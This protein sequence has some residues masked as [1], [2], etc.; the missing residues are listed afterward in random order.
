MVL[1]YDLRRELG[2]GTIAPRRFGAQTVFMEEELTTQLKE[3]ADKLWETERPNLA[4][5]AE[6]AMA[7]SQGRGADVLLAKLQ[8][9]A[10]VHG[11]VAAV[12]HV[13]RV[14]NAQ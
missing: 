11:V 2:P 14:E 1:R 4:L 9:V 10:F 8:R 5:A 6:T 7:A 13:L 12:M 3:L